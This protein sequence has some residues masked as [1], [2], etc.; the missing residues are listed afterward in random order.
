MMGGKNE[1]KEILGGIDAGKV[2][3][4]EPM[5]LHASLAVG[6]KADAMVFIE[7]E[8]QLVA[9]IRRLKENKKK[10]FAAGNLTNVIVKDSGYRGAILLMNGLKEVSCE[11]TNDDGGL[12]F[13]QA[14]AR[15]AEVIEL[16]AAEGFTGL[17]FCSGIPGSVGGAIW[18]NAGAYGREIK[19]V[20]E[21]VYI[22]DATCNGKTIKRKEISFRYRK[23]DFAESTIVLSA[24]FKLK[25]G[26]QLKIKE[27][28]NEILQW[29][30]EKH[31]LDFPS[32][33]SI[34]KNLPGQPA[35]K[36]IEERGLKG[37]TVGGAQVSLKHANF[38]VNSGKAKASDILNLIKLVQSKVEKETGVNLETEVVIIGED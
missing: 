4:D 25:R 5:S 8:N 36:L 19:D 29:R 23:T 34:F 20:L 6:G 30:Q 16:S 26:N 33:G 37:M 3:Y 14:G 31:P 22:L 21:E 7:N 24:K 1:I 9:V 17:E 18:M 38:I 28:I 10:Y 11:K 32:A 35:G 12:I 2:L 15:L 13:A 27:R